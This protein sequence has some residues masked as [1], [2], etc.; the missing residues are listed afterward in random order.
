MLLS[1]P[2]LFWLRQPTIEPHLSWVPGEGI[3]ERDTSSCMPLVGFE[4]YTSS[5]KA[6]PSHWIAHLVDDFGE[7]P[8]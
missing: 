5:L 7:K 4:T 6:G 8:L 3:R 1:H 2:P